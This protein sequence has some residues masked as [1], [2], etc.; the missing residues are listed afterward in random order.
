MTALANVSLNF[1]TDWKYAPAPESASHVKIN[2]RYDLFINGKFAA[3]AKGEYFDTINPA[4]EKKL[5]EVASATSE[6]VDHA[7]KAARTRVR[8]SLVENAGQR[9][10]EIHLSHRPNHAGAC[11]RVGDHRID[12]RR[13]GD[14]RIARCRCSRSRPRIFSITPAGRTNSITPSPARRPSR[15]AWRG[16]SSRGIFRC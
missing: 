4:N 5:A 15:S 10:R 1:A 7:V 14:S 9:A 11:S 2:P 16:R 8:K 13:Q 6:D 12:G 3:P